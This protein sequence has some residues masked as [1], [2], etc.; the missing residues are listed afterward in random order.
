MLKFEE[1][2]G[3]GNKRRNDK[4][5]KKKI[6]MYLFYVTSLCQSISRE[7]IYISI[8]GEH[9]N[10]V[11]LLLWKNIFFLFFAGSHLN[12]NNNILED[13]GPKVYI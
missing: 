3:L 10:I 12:H 8:I 11:V 2:L 9:N 7:Y 4:K 1:G 6:R 5:K 13:N